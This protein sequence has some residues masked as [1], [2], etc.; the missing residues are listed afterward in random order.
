MLELYDERFG[1]RLLLGTAQYPSPEI[2]RRAVCASGAAIVTVSLRRESARERSGQSFWSL[3]Q[4]LGVKVQPNT[5]GCR[6]ARDAVNSVMSGPHT[7]WGENQP[8]VPRPA[9]S[10]SGV[11]LGEGALA[12]QPLFSSQ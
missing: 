6:P 1:S 11:R 4:D 9:R 7:P 8:L 2:L 12:C 5:A 10:S 3:I